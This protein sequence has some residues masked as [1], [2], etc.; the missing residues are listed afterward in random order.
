MATLFYDVLNQFHALIKL[1][2]PFRRVN[3]ILDFF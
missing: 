2:P 1:Y 3:A